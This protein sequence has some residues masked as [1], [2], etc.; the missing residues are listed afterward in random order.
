LLL[1]ESPKALAC[2]VF[3]SK[4]CRAIEEL[5]LKQLKNELLTGVRREISYS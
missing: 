5:V 4:K 1:N 2:G 3:A